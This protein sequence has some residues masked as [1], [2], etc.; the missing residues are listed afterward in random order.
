MK[1]TQHIDSCFH[2]WEAEKSKPAATDGATKL[3]ITMLFGIIALAAAC[4]AV[5]HLG[6][7]IAGGFDA[8]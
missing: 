3:F 2:Q 4:Y 5:S 6:A 8:Y 7:Y 1:R